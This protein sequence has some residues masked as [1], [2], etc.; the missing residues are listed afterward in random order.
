MSLIRA[1]VAA[2]LVEIGPGLVGLALFE[3][4]FSQTHTRGESLRN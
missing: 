1:S 4:P 2:G 3:G